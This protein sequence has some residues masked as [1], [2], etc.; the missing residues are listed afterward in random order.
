MGEVL[1]DLSAL[2]YDAKW[3]RV[4]A[5]AFGAP[6]Q[7]D[8]I[9]I[10]AY[11]NGLGREGAPLRQTAPRE[12]ECR[13]AEAFRVPELPTPILCGVDDGIP[14]RVDRLRALGNSVVVP[15]AEAIGRTIPV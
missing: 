3:D 9:F 14:N 4:S 12:L 5:S 15:V 13:T 8:R 1:G 6:H 11:A 2:G 7:R 10:I